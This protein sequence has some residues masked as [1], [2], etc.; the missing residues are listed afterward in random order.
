MSYT[1]RLFLK[2]LGWSGAVLA[3]LPFAGLRAETKKLAVGFDKAP[4]LKTAGGAAVLKI[5][6]RQY[7]F[8]RESE[9]V[10]RVLDAECTHHQCLLGWDVGEKRIK[11]PCHG[12]KFET[13]GKVVH[14][15]ALKD[16]KAYVARID[17]ERII[18][19][20]EEQP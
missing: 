15:P 4:A 20:V 13:N 9:A 1:R 7:L 19:E 3:S 6:G 18:F 5:K 16:L 8:I 10:I 2:A 11:C 17:G 12:S 14:G